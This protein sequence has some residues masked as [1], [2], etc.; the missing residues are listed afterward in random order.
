VLKR[1]T[2]QGYVASDHYVERLT[3]VRTE[4]AGLLRAGSLRA[5]VSEFDGLESAPQALR[6]VFEQASPYIGKRV[7]RITDG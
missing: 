4:L 7:V 5:V 3:S 2:L 6:S 1:T